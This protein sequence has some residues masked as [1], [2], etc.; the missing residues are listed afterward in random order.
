MDCG[1]AGGEPAFSAEKTRSRSQ[2]KRNREWGALWT[3]LFFSKKSYWSVANLQCCIKFCHTTMWL[4][5]THKKYIF[6]LILF[7]VVYHWILNIVPYALQ[8]DFVVF[9]SS[10]SPTPSPPLTTPFLMTT[11][12]LGPL[13]FW[14]NSH[15][16]CCWENPLI[17][18]KRGK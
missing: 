15:I 1:D 11:S 14:M 2:K 9:H 8:Q 5:Y 4:S 16:P 13:C 10:V 18:T 6:F 17:L 3:H 7:H 12:C